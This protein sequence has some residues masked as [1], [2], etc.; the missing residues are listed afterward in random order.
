[1][2]PSRPGNGPAA[3]EP[4]GLLHRALPSFE[5]RPQQVRMA[6]EVDEALSAGRHLLI[7]AGTGVGKS[8]AYLVP[9]ILWA[10][11]PGDHPLDQRRVVVSTHTRALQEQLSR[12]D[13]PLLERALGAAGVAFS[14][15][16]LMGSENYLCAQR[17]QQARQPQEE[18]LL[19]GGEAGLLRA[20][21]QHA[22][23]TA[24]GL[25]SDIPF[26]VPDHLWARVCRDRDICLGA[27]GPFWE[28]CLY[29]RDLERS[30]SAQILVVN[31]ALFFL[32][33]ATGGRILPPHAAVI[34]DEAHRVEDAALAQFG[35]SVSDRAIARLIDDL[36]LPPRAARGAA[37]AD[38]SGEA[39][40]AAASDVSDAA[41]RF[42][43][44]VRRGLAAGAGRDR[45]SAGGRATTITRVRH[46]GLVDDRMSAPLENLQGA[47]DRSS[48]EERDPARALG[49]QSLA[50]RAQLLRQRIVTFLTQAMQDAVYWVEIGAGRRATATLRATPIEVAPALRETLFGGTR[51]VVL[52]S[53]T[54]TAAGSFEH[55]R[56][57]LGLSGAAEAA[58]GSPFD[59]S[60]QALLYLPA[61]MPDPVGGSSDYLE[62][63]AGECRRLLAASDGGTFILFTSYAALDRTWQALR[64]DAAL[65]DLR[66]LRHEP[67]AASS[68][69]EE[70]RM[71]RR[72]VLLGTLTF[73][74]GRERS[75]N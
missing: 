38:H 31:H 1:M 49:L 57:R 72:G 61:S 46:A 35:F 18:V 73:W 24:S 14:H 47:L 16:L 9:A 41:G 63:V 50:Q 70:F 71:T 75:I 39:L 15:A 25:R 65:R 7:E 58:L 6:A 21:Q 20:L 8:L 60:R 32:D 13:L 10:T 51:A 68:I 43:G 23:R 64:D 62:A 52:T 37:S 45:S 12:K 33:L 17:L 29:R 42:F 55:M 11:R 74:Q 54:L 66:M 22:G 34:L 19:P 56:R 67:G 48:R 30:R 59:Y 2:N 3:F 5:P 26:A 27:R 40:R 44:E 36:A 4:G 69:L 53:A 28:S